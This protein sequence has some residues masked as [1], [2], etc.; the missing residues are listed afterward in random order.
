M[1]QADAS[2]A[3]QDILKRIC[4]LHSELFD[5]ADCLLLSNNELIQRGDSH[6]Q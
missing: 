2:Q 3:A 1:K 6:D 4:T 5:S